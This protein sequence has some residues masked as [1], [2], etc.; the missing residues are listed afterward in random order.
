MIKLKSLLV[1][2]KGQSLIL[3]LYK[4]KTGQ[5]IFLNQST[6]IFSFLLCFSYF[7]IQFITTVIIISISSGLD[8][9]III[10]S[11]TSVWSSIVFWPLANSAPF[12]SRKYK[13]IA[14]AILLLPSKKLW[15]F[16]TKYSK[17]AAFSSNVG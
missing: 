17:C 15:F 7:F 13:N 10:V 16:V 8:S 14:A 1:K 4:T 11:A 2:L 9:A 5:L 6:V 3:Y 12:L